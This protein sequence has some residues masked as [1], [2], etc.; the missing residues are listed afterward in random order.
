MIKSFLM[1]LLFLSLT[2][3]SLELP[4][5]QAQPSTDPIIIVF[6]GASNT[7]EGYRAN[8]SHVTLL[9]SFGDPWED[10]NLI[11]EGHAGWGLFSYYNKPNV[12]NEHIMKHKPNYIFIQLGG[13]DAATGRRNLLN[14]S[15]RYLLDTIY[16]LDVNNTIRQIF[17]INFNWGL[18]FLDFTEVI[19]EEFFYDRSLYQNISKNYDLFLLDFF[20]VFENH[21]EYY[22]NGDGHI[23]DLGQQVI[24]EQIHLATSDIIAPPVTSSQS[25]TTS[26][27]ISSSTISQNELINSTMGTLIDSNDNVL[28]YPSVIM[29][30]S[31][32]SMVIR[33][34]YWK[35]KE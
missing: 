23:N 22:I 24:A 8:V 27:K 20:N 12:I 11:N 16:Q 31:A 15:Y 13:N 1:L 19:K 29:N 34:R 2:N 30:I 21:T 5:T 25:T 3:L 9:K 32:I 26:S 33:F 35:S 10:A 17:M 6:V 4:I 28:Y 18:F 14:D 7:E